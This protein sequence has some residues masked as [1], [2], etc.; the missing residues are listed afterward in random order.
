MLLS[1]T[2][3]ERKLLSLTVSG[4]KRPC[5]TCEMGFYVKGRG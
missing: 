3:A 1:L 2:V 5:A 4:R